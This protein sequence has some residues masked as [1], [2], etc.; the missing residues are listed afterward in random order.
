MDRKIK[1]FSDYIL[2]SPS[3]KSIYNEFSDE[4]ILYRH[5]DINTGMTLKLRLYAQRPEKLRFSGLCAC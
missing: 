4:P 2:S 5:E 3:K 1:S